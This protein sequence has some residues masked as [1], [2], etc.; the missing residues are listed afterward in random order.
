MYY[1]RVKKWKEKDSDNALNKDFLSDI[2]I[3]QRIK[4]PASSAH[5]SVLNRNSRSHAIIMQHISMCIQFFN[6]SPGPNFVFESNRTQR[7]G[8]RRSSPRPRPN[9]REVPVCF[10]GCPLKSL[11]SLTP[12]LLALSPKIGVK[13]GTSGPNFVLESNRTQSSGVHRS[14][15]PPRTNKEAC[16]AVK[17]VYI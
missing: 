8:I 16:L 3:S 15:P 13:L 9:K 14:S 4:C 7:T 17:R 2:V 12:L 1:P 5:I 6:L 11:L 10:S